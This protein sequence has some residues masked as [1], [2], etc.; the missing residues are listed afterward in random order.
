MHTPGPASA[1]S[2]INPIHNNTFGLSLTTVAHRLASHKPKLL[3]KMVQFLSTATSGLSF[4]ALTTLI[5]LSTIAKGNKYGW[6]VASNCL[7]FIISSQR[8]EL[9]LYT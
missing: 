5:Y 8:S 2:D 9:R 1:L 6:H 3:W 4:R 7:P